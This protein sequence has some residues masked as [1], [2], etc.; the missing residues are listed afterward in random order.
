MKGR[1]K[2]RTTDEGKLNEVKGLNDLKDA[3][4][5]IA[6]ELADMAAT[7][8]GVR[9]SPDGMD[10]ETKKLGKG[11]LQKELQLF[12]QIERLFHRSKLGRAL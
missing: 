4:Y 7:I 1:T 6:D 2:K 8:E 11:G 12:K 10:W 9:N 5:G 3:Y